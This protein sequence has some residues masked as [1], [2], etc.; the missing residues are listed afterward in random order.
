MLPCTD[1]AAEIWHMRSPSILEVTLVFLSNV[2]TAVSSIRCVP[3]S[4]VPLDHRA[5]QR[6]SP[7]EKKGYNGIVCF[8]CLG[9]FF[10]IKSAVNSLKKRYKSGKSPSG[11]AFRHKIPTHTCLHPWPRRCFLLR[12]TLYLFRSDWSFLIFLECERWMV[13]N[14]ILTGLKSQNLWS[15]VC[16]FFFFLQKTRW[17]FR[18]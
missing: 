9:V 12:R 10:I 3:Q 1:H 13:W 15:F 18:N 14:K 7:L 11:S 5:E 16:C 4:A 6:A 2:S 17:L 8:L